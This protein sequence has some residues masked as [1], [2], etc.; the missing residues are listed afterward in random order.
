[1]IA[2]P[3]SPYAPA[4]HALVVC[5]EASLPALSGEL[6]SLGFR[7]TLAPDPYAAMAELL[8]RPLVYDAVVL[9]LP[10]VYRDELSLIRTLRHRMP[11]VEVLIAHSDG[12]HAA[13]AEALRLGATGLLGEEGI[14]RLM[15]VNAS[16]APAA[17]RPEPAAAAAARNEIA[18][19]AS[20]DRA[21]DPVL[22]DDNQP[23]LTADEL[24]ALLADPPTM[25]PN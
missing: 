20:N 3:H 12:R 19:S 15:Q 11:H 24:R 1:M 23:L 18:P 25:P 5:A 14:H 9:S 6:E 17:I 2:D 10:A 7:V 16:F 4:G 13:M 22:T 8:E 21:D